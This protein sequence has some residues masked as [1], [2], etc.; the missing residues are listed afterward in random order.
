MRLVTR[1]A[2]SRFNAETLSMGSVFEYAGRN[3]HHLPELIRAKKKHQHSLATILEAMGNVYGMENTS[4][5][6]ELSS[7]QYTWDIENHMVPTLRFTRSITATGEGRMPFDIFLDGKY[8]SKGDVLALENT[9]QLYVM[10]EGEAAS[11]EEYRYTVIPVG[12][13]PSLAIDTA[14]M[15]ENYTARFVYFA[16]TEFSE[17]GNIKLHSNMERHTN[18]MTKIRSGQKYS[19]DYKAIEDK[20]LVDEQDLKNYIKGGQKDRLKLL[21]FT[22]IEQAVLDDFLLKANGAML[23]GRS[24]IDANT[25]RPL[26]T[27][28]KGEAVYIGDGLIAQ[29]ERYGHYIDIS[30]PMSVKHFQNAID[31]IADRRGQSMGNHILAIVN[32]K[33][34]RMKATALR[35]AINLFAPQNNGTWFFSKDPVQGVARPGDRTRARRMQL[36][37]E[38]AVGAT[39]NTY[40]YEGNTITFLVDEALTNHYPDKAYG[41]FVDN[42]VYEDRT[43]EKP[44]IHMMTL[45]GRELVQSHVPGIGGIDG[46]TNGITSSRLDASSYDIVG[47]RGLVVKN[48]YAGVIFAER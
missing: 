8:F 13:S 32:R 2:L 24:N 12:N 38:V 21:P 44:G 30:G 16:D 35:D 31:Y 34:S 25:G 11:A 6:D 4:Q 27:D 28:N 29:I 3:P 26:I 41:I 47:W 19:G 9:Q 33:F 40:I 7:I 1:D 22:S 37:H 5:L 15:A 20:Y 45:K 17:Y 48:P 23:W 42:S 39:F 43:G 14:Y 46:R 18:W 10:Q 36:P